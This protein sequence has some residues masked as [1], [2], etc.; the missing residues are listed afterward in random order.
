MSQIVKIQINSDISDVAD[1]TAATMDQVVSNLEQLRKLV[2]MVKKTLSDTDVFNESDRQNLKHSLPLLD[3]A[4]M[5]LNKIDMRL[6]DVASI[7]SGLVSV[8]E[9]PL[10]KVDNKPEQ[11]AE[12]QQEEEM[13]DNIS[14]R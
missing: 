3:D 14:T 10:E 11:A 12:L 8:F 9:K 6:G 4:K 7:S 1:I 5:L 2:L 13:H